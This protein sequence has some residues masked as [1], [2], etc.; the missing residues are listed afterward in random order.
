MFFKLCFLKT[1]WASQ[2]FQGTSKGSEWQMYSRLAAFLKGIFIP[3]KSPSVFHYLTPSR[4]LILVKNDVLCKQIQDRAL[5]INWSLTGNYEYLKFLIQRGINSFP[6]RIL[7]GSSYHYFFMWWIMSATLLQEWSIK[8]W[9]N[10]LFILWRQI[11]PFNLGELNF[12]LE[13]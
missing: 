10:F 13:N 4:H 6:S 5:S 2:S 9:Y 11:F 12:P 1:T 7:P 8:F 3:L